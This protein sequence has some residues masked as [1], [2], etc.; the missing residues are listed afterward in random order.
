MKALT[1]VG[2]AMLLLLGGL[3]G[4][5][6][7]TVDTCTGNSPDAPY[8]GILTLAFNIAGFAILAWQCSLIG[9]TAASIIPVLCAMQY[10]AKTAM[11]LGGAPA[12]NLISEF[13]P[14][15]FSGDEPALIKLWVLTVTTF[16]LGLAFALWRSYRTCTVTTAVGNDDQSH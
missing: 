15:E 5:L 7:W 10:S 6:S 2:A 12:C 14:W 1:I 9:T 13:G 3:N 16:W 11:L 4:L 8:A